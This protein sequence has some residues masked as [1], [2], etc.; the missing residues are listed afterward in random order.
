MTVEVSNALQRVKTK[1]SRSL[2]LKKT[3]NLTLFDIG[4][5]LIGSIYVKEE[6]G[7]ERNRCRKARNRIL[8]NTERAVIDLHT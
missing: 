4:V 1:E 8:I 3:T 2:V 7:T 6:T 5:L